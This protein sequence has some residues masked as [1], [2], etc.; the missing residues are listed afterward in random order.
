MSPTMI[1]LSLFN[2]SKT[3]I[4]STEGTFN[5]WTKWKYKKY[6]DTFDLLTMLFS[7]KLRVGLKEMQ[8]TMQY[9]NVQE[10]DGDFQSY[11]ALSEIPKMRKYNVNDVL[12]TEELL[13]RCQKDIDLRLAIEKEYGIQAL[14]KDGVNIGK[15]IIEQKYLEKTGKTA[16][17]VKDLRSPCDEIPLKDVI[18]PI[19]KY[20]TPL[21]QN[22]LKEMKSLTVSAGRKGYE[23]HFVLDGLEYC[24]GVGGKNAA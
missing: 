23:K 18:F 11:L 20:D 6:F 17:E 7:S 14:S 5:E 16:E 4:N 9:K 22:L 13:Y 24:V 10:Y 12:S 3:I 15:N 21:L 2:L 19:V 1:C 8:V